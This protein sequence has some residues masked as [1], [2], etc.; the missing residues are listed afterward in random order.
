MCTRL[1]RGT[2]KWMPSPSG[3][4]STLPKVVMTPRVPDCTMRTGLISETRMTTPISSVAILANQEMTLVF[5]AAL[6]RSS[7][8]R[9]KA[10]SGGARPL[11]HQRVGRPHA[12]LLH[13]LPGQALEA[14]AVPLAALE[15]LVRVTLEAVQHVD[16][17]AE[18]GRLQRLA[19]R[20]R[21]RARPMYSAL[22]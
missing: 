2:T 1:T 12:P 13:L 14:P 5:I 6:K 3:C 22:I 4:G 15:V 10:N 20:D 11:R 16:D 21:A 9:A 7:R 18:T 17:V 19:G 8:P